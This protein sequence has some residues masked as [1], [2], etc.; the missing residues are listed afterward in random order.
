LGAKNLYKKIETK[1][2]NHF[3]KQ[4]LNTTRQ[5]PHKHKIRFFSTGFQIATP[6]R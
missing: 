5:K 6:P 4:I 2:K 3:S 1:N